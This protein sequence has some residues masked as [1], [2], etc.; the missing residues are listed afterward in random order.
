MSDPK[1]VPALSFKWLTPIYDLLVERPMSGLRMYADLL[2]A[3][4]QV[5]GKRVLDVGCGTGSL[6]IRI[7]R[8]NPAAVVTG[9][10]GDPQILEIARSKARRQSLEIQ[11]DQVMSFNLPYPDASVEVVLTSMMLHHLS[12]EDKIRTAA[13]LYRVLKPAG[14]LIGLDFTEAR[15]AVGRS[16]KPFASRLERVADNLEGFLPILVSQAG[17]CDYQETHRYVFGSISLFQGY[18]K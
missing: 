17:F 11:F 13:E 16:L 5:E 1:Y 6:A 15:G 9:L 18:K 4:G 14:R 3:L 7:K 8:K 2:E 12:R 10:D